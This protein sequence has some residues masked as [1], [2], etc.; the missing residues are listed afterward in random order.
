MVNCPLG[1]ILWAIVAGSSRIL[2]KDDRS[3]ENQALSARE[4]P[5][6]FSGLKNYSH[7]KKQRQW[8][9]KRSVSVKQLFKIIE[10][11]AV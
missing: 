7:S 8:T 6:F 1:G 2:N 10:D 4:F 5:R 3:C 9:G 11:D